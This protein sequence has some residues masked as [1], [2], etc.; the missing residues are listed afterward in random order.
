MLAKM[1]ERFAAMAD[2]ERTA[3]GTAPATTNTTTMTASDIEG[4]PALFGRLGDDVM[5][6][7]DTKLSLL[8]VELKEDAAVY[9]RAAGGI[10]AGA[11]I[12]GV[13][14]ALALV[15]VAF[16][17]SMLF[18]FDTPAANYAMGF[19]IT[20]ILFIAIGGILIYVMKNRLAARTPVPN[21][22]V[23]EFRKDKQWLKNETQG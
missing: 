2:L 14:L 9:G 18:T 1:G 11:I 13:G 20:G 12:A 8:K 6:L 5:T 15:A 22:S 21:R 10:G 17:V 3:A 23:E 4:L 7:V 16:F 19:L